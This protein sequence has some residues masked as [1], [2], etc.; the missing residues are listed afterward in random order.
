M[1]NTADLKLV[2][3]AILDVFEDYP[4]IVVQ[5]IEDTDAWEFIVLTKHHGH[6]KIQITGRVL[7]QWGSVAVKRY[8]TV[9]AQLLRKELAQVVVKTLKKPRAY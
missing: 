8:V 5:Q 2:K 3:D 9:E 4:Q 7:A 1:A 6:G